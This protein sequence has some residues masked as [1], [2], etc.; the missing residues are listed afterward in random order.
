MSI[1]RPAKNNNLLDWFDAVSYLIPSK[2]WPIDLLWSNT[3]Y[4]QTAHRIHNSSSGLIVSNGFLINQ[5]KN[6]T[7]SKT[8]NN[9]CTYLRKYL[10]ASAIFWEK[11]VNS[12][13]S[14]VAASNWLIRGTCSRV[15]IWP[16][17]GCCVHTSP[18]L[19]SV[20]L[21][22]GFLLKLHRHDLSGLPSTT[23][24]IHQMHPSIHQNMMSDSA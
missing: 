6:Q 2:D 22:M 24:Q 3:E 17:P 15:W 21:L 7:D 4:F 8:M 13:S 12:S 1:S 19:V 18:A 23:S 11:L 9:K 16:W 20:I 14:S 10:K 5:I